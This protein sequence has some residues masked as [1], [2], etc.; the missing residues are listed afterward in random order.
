MMKIKVLVFFLCFFI[1]SALAQRDYVLERF[2]SSSRQVVN[3][4]PCS[5]AE[6]LEQE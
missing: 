5:K 3:F 1:T 4:E 2:S 6:K